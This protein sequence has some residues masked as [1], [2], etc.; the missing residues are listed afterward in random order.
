MHRPR[1]LPSPRG[2]HRAPH[3]QLSRRRPVLYLVRADLRHGRRQHRAEQQG[4]H[5]GGVLCLGPGHPDQRLLSG[6]D[7]V[8]EPWAAGLFLLDGRV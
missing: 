2:A 5:P 3:G 6:A 4:V 1:R 7:F 8:S